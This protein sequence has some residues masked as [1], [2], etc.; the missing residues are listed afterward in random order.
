MAKIL[1]WSLLFF[2]TDL[3]LA[4]V[5]CLLAYLT[6]ML[7]TERGGGTIPPASKRLRL[8]AI[9]ASMLSISAFTAGAVLTATGVAG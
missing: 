8:V 3:V 4:V 7:T 9:A 6:Q 5:T 1:F 2:L